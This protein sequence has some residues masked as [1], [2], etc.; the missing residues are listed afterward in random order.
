MT[1]RNHF[2]FKSHCHLRNSFTSLPLAGEHQRRQVGS[3]LR[4]INGVTFLSGWWNK[5]VDIRSEQENEEE[6]GLATDLKTFTQRPE[7]GRSI[8]TVLRKLNTRLLVFRSSSVITNK[9][10]NMRTEKHS[11]KHVCLP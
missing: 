2:L 3:I 5:P 10:I 8:R 9:S 7:T 4:S 11:T 6:T 1:R